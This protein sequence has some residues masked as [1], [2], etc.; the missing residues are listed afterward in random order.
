M[1]VFD[2][3]PPYEPRR[4]YDS[5]WFNA[6]NR[7]QY[8]K[9]IEK[10]KKFIKNPED[11]SRVMP[12]LEEAQASGLN[13]DELMKEFVG[14][15]DGSIRGLDAEVARLVNRL[16]ELGLADKTVI[17]FTADHGE[18]FH[19]HGRMWHGQTVYG[20]LTNVPLIFYGP[21]FIPPGLVIDQTV[22]NIDI[23]PTLLELSHLALPNKIQG[24][25]LLPLM[26][27]AKEVGNGDAAKLRA[28]AERYG[29]K[30]QPAF[31]EKAP[32]PKT[33]GPRPYDTE[34]YGIVYDGWKLI[35]NSKRSEGTP[36]FELF[37]HKKD[38]LNREN[39][40]DRNP[41]VVKRLA[42]KLEERRQSAIAAALPANATTKMNP[43]EMRRLRSLGYIQ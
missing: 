5:I 33:G 6:Q 22:E 24:Q 18:E 19:E 40:A 43:E 8:D 13:Y 10:L 21:A 17:A 11:R 1:H 4:P 2:A 28:A 26:A 25:S 14:W 38:P 30:D 36:E 15:Y 35:R 20:E 3:H 42:L 37:D 32:T 29:W 39:I 16:K 12:S 23:M 7:E 27:A 31:S 9:D 41:D 34:S